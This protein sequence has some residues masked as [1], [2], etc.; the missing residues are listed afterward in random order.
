MRYE[1]NSG[2]FTPEGKL[3]ATGFRLLGTNLRVIDVL[4]NIVGE[5]NPT[6]SPVPA[7]QLVETA[8]YPGN[9]SPELKEQWTA[10]GAEF[11]QA[12]TSAGLKKLA[13][14]RKG[15]LERLIAV[16]GLPNPQ[17][18]LGFLNLNTARIHN[19]LRPD[20]QA[21]QGPLGWGVAVYAQNEVTKSAA[22]RRVYL[23]GNMR[24]LNNG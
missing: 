16:E 13:N 17:E 4:R 15:I 5:L 22:Y 20:V 21:K 2:Q 12:L 18:A 3:K 6:L 19:L 8:F 23:V 24:G 11:D 9:L 10:Y 7:G 1:F 14:A